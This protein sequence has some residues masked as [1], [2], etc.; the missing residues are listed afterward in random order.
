METSNSAHDLISQLNLP[1]C[2]K[3]LEN[4][5]KQ[6]AAVSRQLITSC[7]GL[8][9][10]KQGEQVRLS[11]WSPL[12]F[13][14]KQYINFSAKR[15]NPTKALWSC[16]IEKTE[17]RTREGQGIS[18]LGDRIPNRNQLCREGAPEIFMGIFLGFFLNH[19][20]YIYIYINTHI[21][22]YKYIFIENIDCVCVC[23]L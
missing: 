8:F 14:Q 15:V 7:A 6:K 19:R 22:I 20:K 23:I 9:S 10:L 17:I 18:N 21:Y 2:Q 16:W 1:S 12:H 5:E 13:S 11:L 4:Q 3:Q